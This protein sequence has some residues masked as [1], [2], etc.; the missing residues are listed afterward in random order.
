MID[1]TSG[2][3]FSEYELEPCKLQ[4]LDYHFL[5]DKKTRLNISETEKKKLY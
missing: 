1:N 4:S 3:F 2:F 5:N